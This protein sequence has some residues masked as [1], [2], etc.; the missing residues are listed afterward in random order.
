LPGKVCLF[1]IGKF[2]AYFNV[3]T[4]GG[5]LAIGFQMVLELR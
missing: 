4:S 3:H 2:S 5:D 1:C